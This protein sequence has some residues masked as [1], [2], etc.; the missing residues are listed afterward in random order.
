MRVRT[1]PSVGLA[2]PNT[3]TSQG[4]FGVTRTHFTQSS[5][6]GNI[7]KAV[8][9]LVAEIDNQVQKRDQFQAAL[10][11][12]NLQTDL[13]RDYIQSLDGVTEDNA[14]N[15]AQ[16]YLE[17]NQPRLNAFLSSINDPET[18]QR[19]QLRTAEAMGNLSIKALRSQIDLT[20]AVNS[21]RLI[22]AANELAEQAY[23]DPDKLPEL[24]QQLKALVSDL[25][26]AGPDSIKKTEDYEARVAELRKWAYRKEA[27]A[28]MIDDQGGPTLKA[29]LHSFE[30]T[31]N[32]PN[33]TAFGHFQF[34]N[35]TWLGLIDQVFPQYAHLSNKEKLALRGNFDVASRMYDALESQNASVLKRGGFATTN[36]NLYALHLLGASGGMRLLNGTPGAKISDLV[37]A[38]VRRVNPAIFKG[39]RTREEALANI[40]KAMGRPVPQNDYSSLPLGT[41]LNI[42]RDAQNEA[43]ASANSY[44]ERQ[45]EADQQIMSDLRNRIPEGD[46]GYQDL[47]ELIPIIGD[48]NVQKLKTELD[49]FN[50][51]QEQEQGLR[52]VL[53][54]PDAVLDPSQQSQVNDLFKTKDKARLGAADEEAQNYAQTVNDLAARGLVPKDYVNTLRGMLR[55]QDVN[56]GIFAAQ[57]L[58][59]VLDANPHS[60]FIPEPLAERVRMFANA[61]ASAQ[62]QELVNDAYRAL[63]GPL[64]AE[65]RKARD[66]RLQEA[67]TNYNDEAPTAEDLMNS[68]INT[69]Q[70]FLEDVLHTDPIPPMGNGASLLLRDAKDTY[71]LLSTVYPHDDHSMLMERVAQ[72]LQHRWGISDAGEQRMFMKYP[73]EKFQRAVNGQ[74]LSAEE[75]KRDLRTGIPRTHGRALYLE[76]DGITH[77]LVANGVAPSYKVHVEEPGTGHRAI[78]YM[79]NDRGTEEPFRYTPYY[80]PET[81]GARRQEIVAQKTAEIHLEE[82][83]AELDLLLNQSDGLGGVDTEEL[84]AA[85]KEKSALVEQ[86]SGQVRQHQI[87][88]GERPHPTFAPP[89]VGERSTAEQPSPIPFVSPTQRAPIRITE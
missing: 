32:N 50:K 30:G 82:A 60:T 53:Q 73:P 22:E 78:L 48:A 18:K 56:K 81:H 37:P 25:P 86:L 54:D 41:R 16:E 14:P 2:T 36:R 51:L 23:E 79:P 87:N 63:F 35:S 15:F 88:L 43:T 75:I 6:L 59:A 19:Y 55:S 26:G 68:I 29:R 61:H 40:S 3:P 21:Q 5:E 42:L 8:G 64:D 74:T 13:N 17:R 4:T 85:I 20:D 72:T 44:A 38:E 24:E 7:A 11:F 1:T 27:L 76:S 31:G 70:S 52:T 66:D 45:A 34:I 47:S 10:D 46:V 57:N 39:V 65:A 77:E 58:K 28:G 9:G 67:E 62:D 33:S 71:K 83:Q 89:A 84:E 49:R 69:Q 80:D 12:T